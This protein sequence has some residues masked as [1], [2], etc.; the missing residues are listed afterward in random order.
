MGPSIGSFLY[1]FGG[2]ACPFGILGMFYVLSFILSVIFITEH[3]A[4]SA[5]DDEERPVSFLRMASKFG[6]LINVAALLACGFNFGFIS[7]SLTSHLE[8]LHMSPFGIGLIFPIAAL[9][10]IIIARPLEMIVSR[11]Y[12][13]QLIISSFAVSAA[14]FAISGPM[15][16]LPFK[17]SVALVIVRQVLFG[18]SQLPQMVATMTAGMDETKRYGFP[19]DVATKA[20]FSAIFHTAASIG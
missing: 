2:F 14:A 17:S 15:Y 18:A 8:K 6:I 7:V 12:H 11:G 13:N 16:P 1:E 5:L 19:D 9:T 20:T 4:V 10:F 3:E